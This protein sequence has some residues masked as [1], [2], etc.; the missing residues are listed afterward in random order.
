MLV[1]KT[2][3]RKVEALFSKVLI[4]LYISHDE[5][6]SVNERSSALKE[7]DNIKEEIRN[8]NNK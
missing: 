5:L 2:R 4:D 8:S 3:L 6:V 7:Y 1:A